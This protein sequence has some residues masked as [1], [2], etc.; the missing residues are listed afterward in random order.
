MLLVAVYGSYLCHFLVGEGEI[1]D[2]DVL[3]DMVG[4]A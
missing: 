4:I 1:E 3:L 2:A